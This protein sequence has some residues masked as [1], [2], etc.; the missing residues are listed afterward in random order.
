MKFPFRDEFTDLFRHNRSIWWKMAGGAA[1]TTLLVISSSERTLSRQQGRV[2]LAPGTIAIIL[3]AAAI[4]GA[5]AAILLSLKDVV[6]RRQATGQRVNWLLQVYF[7]K[8][9]ASLLLCAVTAMAVA[10]PGIIILFGV[11]EL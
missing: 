10:F 11:M 9:L 8:G 1:A 7:G 2:T 3:V 4:L 5:C 6:E